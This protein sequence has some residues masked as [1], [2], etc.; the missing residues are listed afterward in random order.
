MREFA[1]ALLSPLIFAALPSTTNYELN[2][3]SFGSGGTADSSTATYSLEGT[4]GELS[5]PASDTANASVKPGYIES[6]QAHVPKLV[7]LDNNGGEYYNRLHFVIDQQG[8]PSDAKYLIAVS[9]DNFVSDTKYLRADGTL[10][11][12]MSTTYYQTYSSWGGSGG[13]LIIGLEPNMLYSVK[14]KATQ[15]DFTE[16]AFG[17]ALSEATASPSLTFGLETSTQS[18]APFSVNLGTLNA[19]DINTTDSAINTTLTTNGASGANVYILGKNGALKSG[20]TGSQINAVSDDLSNLPRGFGAQNGSVGQTSGGPYV[21]QSPYDVT[22]TYVGIVSAI[23]RSLY[24]SSAPVSGGS[25]TLVLK[26]K[27]A[28]D[29]IAASDYQEILTFIAAGN[30]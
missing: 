9:T 2:S 7:S 4:V 20:S 13:S 21:V 22:G 25:G 12:T 6:K 19:D 17:P 5:G 18:S 29:D 27:S 16:S 10:S 30:F 11:S 23:N 14:L 3:Y 1:L 15:G 24:S 8:N 28:K 26:A